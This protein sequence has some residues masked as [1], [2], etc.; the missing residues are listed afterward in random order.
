MERNTGVE[1]GPTIEISV[2]QLEDPRTLASIKQAMESSR[3]RIG[4]RI[5]NREK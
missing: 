5:A 2:E 4:F 1:D 3:G